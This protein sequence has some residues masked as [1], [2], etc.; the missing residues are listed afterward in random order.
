MK[1]TRIAL[2]ILFA[3]GLVLEGVALFHEDWALITTVMRD[4]PDMVILGI[5]VL[6]GHFFWC[7]C[8]GD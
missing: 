1:K 8:N 7:D 3:L 4:L 2:V 6:L 5:G